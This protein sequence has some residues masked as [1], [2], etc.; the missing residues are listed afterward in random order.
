[1]FYLLSIKLQN[2]QS[3][4]KY[5]IGIP[6]TPPDTERGRE[7]EQEETKCQISV[8]FSKSFREK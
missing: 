8:P 5:Q 6:G 7:G 2:F 3:F 1:M 4:I